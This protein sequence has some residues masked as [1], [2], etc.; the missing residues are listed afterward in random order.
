MPSWR[1]VHL[2][3]RQFLIESHRAPWCYACLLLDKEWEFTALIKFDRVRKEDRY[4]EAMQLADEIFG[5][6]AAT[7]ANPPD[8]RTA[9]NAR[10]AWFWTAHA[11]IN[12]PEDVPSVAALPDPIERTRVQIKRLNESRERLEAFLKA[13]PAAWIAEQD[14]GVVESNLAKLYAASGRKEDAIAAAEAEPPCTTRP[15]SN[16]SR[17]GTGPDPGRYL[18]IWR[19]PTSMPPRLAAG[20]GTSRISP[21]TMAR[22]ST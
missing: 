13:F 7:L 11:L 4:D 17:A 10:R 21:S 20:D 14:L 19:K 3:L 15:V 2:P 9:V 1:K 22:R 12:S 6:A 5:E 8:V 18:A 16:C